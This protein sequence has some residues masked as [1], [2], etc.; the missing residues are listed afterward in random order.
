MEELYV[1]FTS[2]YIFKVIVL[3]ILTTVGKTNTENNELNVFL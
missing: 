3:L 1:Y 2:S